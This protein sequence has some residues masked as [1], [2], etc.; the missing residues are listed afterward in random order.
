MGRFGFGACLALFCVVIFFITLFAS[1]AQTQPAQTQKDAAPEK[2]A[3]AQPVDISGDWQVSWQGRMG[4]EEC[5]LHL[6]QDGTKLTGT[7]K[8]LHGLSSLSGTVDDD[9]KQISFDVKFEGPHPFTTRFTGTVNDG[10]IEGTSQ[11]IG[12]GGSG[13]YLGHAGEIVQPEHPWTAAH[14][15]NQPARTSEASSDPNPPANK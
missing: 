9:K 12:V 7:L 8:S 2:P 13:A 14:I 10:K 4:A 5:V 15:A 1:A 3:H 11:A 6:R